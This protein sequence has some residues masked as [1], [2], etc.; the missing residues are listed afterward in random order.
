MQRLKKI[1]YSISLNLFNNTLGYKNII[2]LIYILLCKFT[3]LLNVNFIKK[4]SKLNLDK[5]SKNKY[6]LK[7]DGLEIIANY[8]GIKNTKSKFNQLFSNEKNFNQEYPGYYFLN[9][10]KFIFFEDDINQIVNFISPIIKIKLNSNFKI[11]WTNILRMYPVPGHKDDNSLLWHFDDNPIGIH[12][13]FIYLTPQD[14]NTGAFRAYNKLHSK[15]IK[16][17]GFLSFTK[18]DR[19]RN[20]TIIENYSKENRFIDA[21]GEEGSILL[22]QNNIIHKANL[23]KS[24]FRDL[25]VLEILPSFQSVKSKN[26]ISSLKN[27]IIKDYPSNPFLA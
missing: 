17:N 23:P 7:D 14:E 24:G 12:K 1:Y 16:Q 4:N 19:E 13:I 21:K 25:I 8:T 18:E 20:Q 3:Y 9:R 15:K 26:I 5:T 2:Y 27:K 10:D 6:S 11:F 22:F